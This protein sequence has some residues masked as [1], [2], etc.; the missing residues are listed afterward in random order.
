MTREEFI[1]ILDSKRYSYRQEENN[2]VVNRLGD[3]NLH[4][5]TT[6]PEGIVFSNGGDVSLSSL[7]TLPE[8]TVF[9]N[10]GQVYLES[11]TTLPEWIVFSNKGRVH[12]ESLIGGWDFRWK[13]NIKGI[14]SKRLLNKMISIGLFNRK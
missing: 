10:G 2:I 6:I 1:Q 8:G 3:V 12:L 11:L 4:S 5:L 7:T 9:S 14:D 13:G